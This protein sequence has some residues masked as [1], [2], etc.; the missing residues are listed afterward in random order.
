MDKYLIIQTS[1]IGD[2]ILAT[3]LIETL[4]EAT[5]NKASIEILVRKGNEQLL[6]NHPLISK[7]HIWNKKNKKY[8]NLFHLVK[9]LKPT[10]Y[11][12]VYNLQRFA[13]TGYVT[14]QLNAEVKV[15][16]NKNPLS[17][18]FD[19]KIEHEIGNGEHEIQRNFKLISADFPQQKAA[20]KPRLYPSES[21]F[22]K[23]EEMLGSI[24]SYVVFAPAS[25]WFTKQAPKEKWIELTKLYA[26]NQHIVFI[27]APSDKAFINEI[28][29]EANEANCL[30]AAGAIS[31]LQSA[32][33][34]KGAKRSFVN[35]SAPLHLASAM[36]A[37]VTA[38]FCST[39]P[40]FGFGPLSDDQRIIETELNLKCR[41]CGL[42]GFKTCPETHFKCGTSLL[43]D[44]KY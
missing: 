21:D 24:K 4:A 22:Q 33:L 29:Y 16:Y 12:R 17:L 38:F 36:N 9:K 2:V 44:S 15:G 14:W 43:I 23:I 34:I 27:G 35:D 32:A 19:R 18:F 10:K 30:N 7:V 26:Q 31:L 3:S 1:F 8:K 41:P 13:S 25:V 11:K 20:L 28:I 6:Q 42:H 39:I 40:S 37:P 5:N